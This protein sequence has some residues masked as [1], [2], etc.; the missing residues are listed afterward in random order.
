MK[1]TLVASLC[2]AL[3]LGAMASNYQHESSLDFHWGDVDQAEFQ[4]FDML[5]RFF[6]TPVQINVAAPLAE[7]AFLGRNSSA[8]GNY[9]RRTL[10]EEG[11]KQSF[12]AWRIGGE[13]MDG[14]HDF[15]VGF[16]FES[17]NGSNTRSALTQLGYF[18]ESDWLVTLDI[19]HSRPDSMGTRTEFGFST[20]R[21]MRLPTGDHLNVE[22]G[23]RDLRSTSRNAYSFG[24]DYYFG[25][26]LSLGLMYDWRSKNI[27]SQ[28]RDSFTVRGQWFPMPN[29]A[30]RAEAS[31]DSFETGE[32][33]YTL[34]ASYRF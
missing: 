1:L 20:K 30:L 7:A 33:L 12:S 28:N 29:L 14:N 13:Y 17:I 15:Y 34:G 8:Y 16:D 9:L 6:L 32:D 5:H 23:Y 26:T 25:K 24:G 18:V 22:A 2:S 27:I 19:N 31:F 10:K 3:S 21:L 11:I 4:R